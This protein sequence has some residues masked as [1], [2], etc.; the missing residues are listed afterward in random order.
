MRKLFEVVFLRPSLLSLADKWWR[1]KEQAVRYLHPTH[2]LVPI[3]FYKCPRV[4]GY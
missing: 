3:L 1:N 2:Q 4:L